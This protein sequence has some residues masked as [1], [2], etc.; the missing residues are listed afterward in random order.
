M[1]HILRGRRVLGI[2]SLIVTAVIFA[3]GSYVASIWVM[4]KNAVITLATEEA[5]LM[6]AQVFSVIAVLTWLTSGIFGYIDVKKSSVTTLAKVW[7]SLF[8]SLILLAQIAVGAAVAV[9]ID[10]QRSLMSTIFTSTTTR[11]ERI[12]IE[13]TGRINV[14]LLGGDAGAGRWGLRP[15]SISVA[16]IDTVSGAIT[17]VGIPRNLQNFPFSEGS[18]MKALFPN[19]LRRFLPLEFCLHPRELRSHD[20][21]G[22]H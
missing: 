3:V 16:S 17:L 12:E 10:A 11:A 22:G 2:L 21:R 9:N 14:L 19:G 7:T 6:G 15:D 8:L 4:D 20:L 13:K 18:P 1:W 5:F